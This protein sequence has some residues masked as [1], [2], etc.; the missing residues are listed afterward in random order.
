MMPNPG[1]YWR[2]AKESQLIVVFIINVGRNHLGFRR[3]LNDRE[4]AMSDAQTPPVRVVRA[5]TLP[6]ARAVLSTT[7]ARWLKLTE[8]LPSDLLA[9]PPL[10]GEWSAAEC[11]QHLL[12]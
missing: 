2:Q 10:P 11:L 8:T 6:Q 9:R 12:D 7:A 4:I 1:V 3:F 5:N